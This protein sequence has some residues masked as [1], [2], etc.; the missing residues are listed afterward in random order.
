MLRSLRSV[1]LTNVLFGLCSF[2]ESPM[3]AQCLHLEELSFP[4]ACTRSKKRLAQHPG[5]EPGPKRY[6]SVPKFARPITRSATHL[7][8]H[9]LPSNAAPAAVPRFGETPLLAQPLK[10]RSLA[11]LIPATVALVQ[12]DVLTPVTPPITE[13]YAAARAGVYGTAVANNAVSIATQ[14]AARA[15]VTWQRATA[16]MTVLFSSPF[17]LSALMALEV[18]DTHIYLDDKEL[19]GLEWTISSML[20]LHLR[21]GYAQATEHILL[22][23]LW[24]LEAW[25]NVWRSSSTTVLHDYLKYLPAIDG[26]VAKEWKANSSARFHILRKSTVDSQMDLL[27]RLNWL[28][29]LDFA[30]EVEPVH[31]MIFK[32]SSCSSIIPAKPERENWMRRMA[33]TCQILQHRSHVM[34]VHRSRA[35]SSA[36]FS[37]CAALPTVEEDAYAAH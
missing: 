37:R 29:R 8:K 24:T 11:S 28:V 3:P 26:T 5:Q 16:F 10:P 19:T 17:V 2:P 13:P 33:D 23:E 36:G 18:N 12:R 21:A 27:K 20:A 14:R 32:G 7:G 4:A 31:A 35:C 6:F 22:A 30:A 9:S 34:N 25:G 1:A 15:E